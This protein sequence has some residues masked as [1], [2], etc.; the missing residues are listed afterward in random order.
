[1]QGKPVLIKLSLLPGRYAVCKL[2]SQARLPDWAMKS[3]F[4]SVT[5]TADEL[6]IVCAESDVPNGILSES[7]WRKLKLEGP[8][9]FNLV[10]ILLAVIQPLA[11]KGISIFAISTYDTDYVLVHEPQLT[12]AV[13]ALVERGHQVAISE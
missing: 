4:C 8:F 9:D 6:S 5:R 11:E 1:M 10:G 13:V 3:A 12:Q 7:G 2:K